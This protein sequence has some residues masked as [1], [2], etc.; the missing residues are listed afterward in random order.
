MQGNLEK[1]CRTLE[2]QL[3]ELKS[4]EEEQQRLINELTTQR[5]RLQTEA[6]GTF[7]VFTLNIT[8]TLNS[9]LSEKLCTVTQ[10]HILP[11]REAPTNMKTSIG[12]FFNTDNG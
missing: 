2:D 11:P 6:G 5:G 12:A 9:Q 7:T 10:E 4:K 1:M 3:S 8:H